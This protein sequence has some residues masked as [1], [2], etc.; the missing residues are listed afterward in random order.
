MVR[1]MKY[2]PIYDAVLLEMVPVAEH[3]DGKLII[4]NRPYWTPAVMAD[5]IAV[6][7]GHKRPEA[8][9]L[10]PLSVRPGE[11]VWVGHKAGQVVKFPERTENEFRI[12]R[13]ADILAVIE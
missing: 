11:R 4:E 12:V 2:R 3:H 5:V 10:V 1:P 9:E 6:G 7:N 8:A 13:E